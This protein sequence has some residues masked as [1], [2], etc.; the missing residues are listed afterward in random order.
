MS[1]AHADE[2]VARQQ[3]VSDLRQLAGIGDSQAL[4][5]AHPVL[6]PD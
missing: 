5:Y 2:H 1:A 3:A 6:F 4:Q